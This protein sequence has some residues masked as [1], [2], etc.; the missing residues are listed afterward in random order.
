M[1]RVEYHFG[2]SV[3]MLLAAH[4]ISPGAQELL[5]EQ[6]AAYY[7]SG[8]TLFISSNGMLVDRLRPPAP[9]EER[10]MRTL[11]TGTRARV[12]FT[13]LDRPKEWI[14]VKHLSAD[15]DVSTAT[16]SEVLQALERN[17][18]VMTEGAGPTKQ[19]RLSRPGNLLDAWAKFV[20]T[21][22]S[23]KQRRYFIPSSAIDA[24]YRIPE[25][26]EKY[27]VDYALTGEAAAQHY[28]P[29][30]THISMLRFRMVHS[31]K[32]DAALSELD[33]KLVT[34]GA[35]ISVIEVASPKDIAYRKR[36]DGVWYAH[37]IQVYLDLLRLE[38]RA[39]D[40][41]KHL[42]EQVIGF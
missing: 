5:R 3:L 26:L 29:W 1:K 16:A 34:E 11:F 18:W 14:N 9:S 23:L 39:P 32:L 22:K 19:R 20:E 7:D 13:M 42:R 36:E 4:S 31:D 33:A 2:D 6:K 37:P 25:M 24:S 28:A 21:R 15:A 40:A 41:A 38:G 12:L 27:R 30:L 35:N 8:G 17:E 10:A